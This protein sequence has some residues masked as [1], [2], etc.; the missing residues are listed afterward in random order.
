MKE[1][2]AEYR[3]ARVRKDAANFEF[4]EAQERFKAA[5]KK[6]AQHLLDQKLRN[7]TDDEG[8]QYS[9]RPAFWYKKGKDVTEKVL[10]WLEK[11]QQDPEQYWEP[12]LKTKRLTEYLKEVY[13]AEGKAPLPDSE[14]GVPEFMKLDTTPTIAVRGWK[15]DE[16]EDNN[17]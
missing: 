9:L 1:I 5:E 12:K 16:E 13:E 10:H 2:L 17:E 15:E 11:R 14:T 4:K 8:R 3:E 6:L 7:T